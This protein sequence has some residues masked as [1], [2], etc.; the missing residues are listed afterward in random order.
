[1]D[2]CGSGGGRMNSNW[3]VGSGGGYWGYRAERQRSAPLAILGS[4]Q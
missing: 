1:M 2:A 3:N 4:P